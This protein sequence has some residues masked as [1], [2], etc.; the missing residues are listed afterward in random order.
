MKLETRQ[1]LAELGLNLTPDMMR[2]TQAIFAASHGGM[3]SATVVTR[4]HAYGPHERHRLDIFR[5]ESAKAAPVLVYVHGGGFVMGDKRTPDTPFHDNIGDFAARNGMVGVTITYRLAPDNPWPAGPEDL[6][7]LV[8]WLQENIAQHGGDPEQVF[9]MGQSAGAVHVASYCAH[10]RFHPGGKAGIAG[11]LLISCIYDVA[12][13][14]ANPFH[15]AYYGEDES[16]YAGCSTQD[17]LISSPIPWLATVS[18]FDVPDFQKQAAALVAAYGKA[19]SRYPR[20]HYLTGHNHLSPG[21][22]VGSPG[23]TL[24]PIITQ[25]IAAQTA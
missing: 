7:R 9:L 13:A 17:G 1:K 25:F 2:A 14:D 24:E 10:E 16:F 19:H 5:Q 22:E 20:M 6:A 23:S 11:A 21:L 15:K 3:D 12:R 8:T 4:D 18:E